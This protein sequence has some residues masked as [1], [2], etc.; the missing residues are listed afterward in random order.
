MSS[1]LPV[2]SEGLKRDMGG[3][4]LD[5]L[6]GGPGGSQKASDVRFRFRDGPLPLPRQAEH[7]FV[8]GKRG[9]FGSAG[10]LHRRDKRIRVRLA[11]KHRDDCGGVDD[12]HE[13]PLRSS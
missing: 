6:N 10:S 5:R 3:F 12:D 1:S 13:S 2:A 11:G 9:R 7:G 4:R 8:K